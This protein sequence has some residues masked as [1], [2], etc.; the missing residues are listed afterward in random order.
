MVVTS[1]KDWNNLNQLAIPFIKSTDEKGVI[2][3][4][5]TVGIFNYDSQ[6]MPTITIIHNGKDELLKLPL[7]LS[8]WA[9]NC[10]AMAHSGMETFPSDVEFG[11]LDDR[12]YAEIK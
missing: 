8:Q 9:L 11:V 6:F 12:Y 4:V 1:Y 2:Y 3:K 10:V 7:E 5:K